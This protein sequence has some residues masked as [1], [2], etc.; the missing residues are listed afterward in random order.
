LVA[1]TF[2]TFSYSSAL[3][4]IFEACWQVNVWNLND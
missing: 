3:A 1:N 2:N 4:K